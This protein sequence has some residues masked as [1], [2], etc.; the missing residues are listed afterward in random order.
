M[1]IEEIHGRYVTL[2]HRFRA[3]WVYQQLLQSLRKVFPDVT[4]GQHS[5]EFQLVYTA[6]KEVSESLHDAAADRLKERLDAIDARITD[7]RDR[8][9]VEDSR[10]A[11][12]RLRQFFQ[13]YQRHDE[14]ILLQLSRFY[15]D[16]SAHD[17]WT[18]E[19][20]DKLDYL[21]TRI[22]TYEIDEE[23]DVQMGNRQHLD[24]VFRSLWKLATA[25]EDAEVDEERLE[26]GLREVDSVRVELSTVKD[27]DELNERGL[28]ERYRKLKHELG[29][30][31]VE[32]ALGPLLLAANLSFKN[33]IRR[34]HRR[35]EQR[36][37]MDY[38]RIFELEGE[39]S[40]D[41][42]LEQELSDFREE[43][44]AFETRLQE[45]HLR[46]TDLARI[47]GKV[48]SL[49]PRLQGAATHPAGRPGPRP[50]PAASRRAPEP[51]LADEDLARLVAALESAPSGA[52]PA[53]TLLEPDLFPLRLERR[54]VVAYR[55]L[56]GDQDKG[57][58][59]DREVEEMERFLLEAAALRVRCN[60]LA[61]ELR[62]A[63]DDRTDLPGGPLDREARQKLRRGDRISRLFDHY[64]HLAVVSNRGEDAATLELLR[65]RFLRHYSGLWLLVYKHDLSHDAHPEP[66]D[67]S[68][69]DLPD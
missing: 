27:L 55:R 62:D 2:S 42:D 40:L 5:G 33:M 17:G 29:R 7:L 3:G 38:Q 22:G 47:R 8:L 1:T 24:E 19:R 63:V 16:L 14:K 21:L 43:I 12:E 56:Y 28:L 48:R 46:L 50:V 11:P 64:L 65:M 34:V 9:A 18:P 37:V 58:G 45:D 30:Y 23:R 31:V 26:H 60:E 57:E 10:V 44:E 66:G 36:I 39:V 41:G 35:E 51:S 59:W 52:S 49:L 61:E 68:W 32:P 25:G 53:K 54:E 20:I 67:S 6:L 69:L 15:V 4:G 13:R